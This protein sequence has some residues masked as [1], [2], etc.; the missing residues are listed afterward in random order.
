MLDSGNFKFKQLLEQSWLS[1]AE[2]YDISN[3]FN[4]LSDDRKI[5]I[6]DKWPHYLNEILK[7]RQESFDKRRDNIARALKNIDDIV[8]EAILR[9][10]DE[11]ERKRQ[12]MKENNEIVKNAQSYDEIRKLQNLQ[13]LIR[14]DFNNL[15]K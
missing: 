12:E 4:Y 14:R 8:N 10:K 11:E 9:K 1:V 3:I 15:N 7:I 13:N 5:D 2:K 6:I